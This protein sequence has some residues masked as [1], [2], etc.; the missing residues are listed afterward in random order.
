M[1]TQMCEKAFAL[2]ELYYSKQLFIQC[3]GK[4]SLKLIL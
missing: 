2:T 3:H 4:S 1:K